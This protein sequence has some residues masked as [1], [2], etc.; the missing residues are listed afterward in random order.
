ML[1]H[2][3]EVVHIGL[4]N[5]TWRP[6]GKERLEPTIMFMRMTEIL[7]SSTAFCRPKK[8]KGYHGANKSVFRVKEFLGRESK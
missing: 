4:A 3:I 7:H 1:S 6:Y 8:G 2:F 5:S